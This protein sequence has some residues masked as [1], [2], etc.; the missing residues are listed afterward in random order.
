[1]PRR[2]AAAVEVNFR[3]VLPGVA[4]G[5]AHHDLHAFI[6]HLPLEGH[7]PVLHFTVFKGALFHKQR[8][9][10]LFGVRPADAHNGD[11]ARPRRGGQRGDGVLIV[12]Q[13]F[14]LLLSAMGE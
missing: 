5:R 7:V 10:E 8:P 2:V 9:E 3:H 11:T 13:C 6:Q 1:M 4:V 14:I 12:I